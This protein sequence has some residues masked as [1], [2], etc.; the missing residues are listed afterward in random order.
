[1]GSDSPDL[2]ESDGFVKNRKSYIQSARCHKAVGNLMSYLAHVIAMSDIGQMFKKIL[3][4][5]RMLDLS[6]I[7]QC[8]QM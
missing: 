5:H 2:I 8:D 7:L 4:R 1:M 6:N 3:I